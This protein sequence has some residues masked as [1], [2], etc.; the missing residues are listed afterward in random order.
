MKLALMFYD[1]KLGI[2][3][4]VQDGYI[5]TSNIEGEKAMQKRLPDLCVL[6][7]L[8]GSNALKTKTLPRQFVDII[9]K[10]SRPDII[11]AA[12]IASGD[13]DF[14]KLVK[15]ASLPTFPKNFYVML[16]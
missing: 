14:E 1:T 11:E 4:K 8:A 15:L 12:G 9:K 3:E 6:Y 2:L 5:Y 16:A 7:D 10:F 13:G